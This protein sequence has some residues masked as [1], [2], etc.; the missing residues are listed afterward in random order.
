[1]IEYNNEKMATQ[2]D[3]ENDA[4]RT[5]KRKIKEEMK[6]IP[7]KLKYPLKYCNPNSLLE[8]VQY[9]YREGMTNR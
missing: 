2:N 9:L 8:D 3:L 1:M 4:I 5:R 6:Q 7:L